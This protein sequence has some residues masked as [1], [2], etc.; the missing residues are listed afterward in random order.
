VRQRHLR[1]DVRRLALVAL[2]RTKKTM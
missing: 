1:H 2:Q